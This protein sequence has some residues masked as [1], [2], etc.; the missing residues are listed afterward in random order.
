MSIDH[1]LAHAFERKSAIPKK[2]LL[3]LALRRGVGMVSVEAV[4]AAYQ[5]RAAS[6]EV[7][8]REVADQEHC[9]T[10]QVLLEEQAMLAHAREGRTDVGTDRSLA[11]A[12]LG[13]YNRDY[14]H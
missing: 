13:R 4:K 5:G 2:R 12:A 14:F 9:T 10:K 1:A 3:E 11:H 6:G 7:L 8:A